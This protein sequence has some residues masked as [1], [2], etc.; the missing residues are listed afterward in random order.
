MAGD[1]D[2]D[3]DDSGGGAASGVG[4]GLVDLERELTCSICTDVLYQ[5]LT[6]LDCLH[7]FCGACV[8]EWFVWQATSA[9]TSTRH[10]T[11]SPYTC[12]SCRESVRGTKADWRLTALLEGFLRANP[13]KAKSDRDKQELGLHYKPGDD[14]I[15][16]VA[17]SHADEDSEDERLM[18]EIRELSMAHVDPE[19]AQ[20][21]TERASRDR[22]RRRRERGHAHRP[23]GSSSR[24]QQS[25]RWVAQQAVRQQQEEEEEG[26]REEEEA[27]RQI[28]H[29][30]SLRSLLSNSDANSSEDVQQEILQSIYSEG[31][32]NG[33][34]I[35]NLTPAQE[36][37]LTERIAEAYRRRRRHRDR[38]RNR[39]REDPS[40]QAQRQ[41]AT[42]PRTHIAHQQQS[43]TRT[44]PPVARPHIFEAQASTGAERQHRRS[45]SSTSQH[46]RLPAVS[47]GHYGPAA[48]SATDLSNPPRQEHPLSV[49]RPRA[50]S[51]NTRSSTDTTRMLR[52]DTQRVR[53]TSNTLSAGGLEQPLRP[54]HRDS[55]PAEPMRTRTASSL[56]E[57]AAPAPLA[58]QTAL[59]AHAA[60][61][62]D[63]RLLVSTSAF[64]PEVVSSEVGFLQSSAVTPY[65]IACSHCRRQA[66]G[67]TL[68]YNCSKCD[69]GM[70]NLCLQCYRDGKG[71]YHWYGFGLMAMYRWQ[72]AAEAEH[73]TRSFEYPHTLM[74]RKYIVAPSADADQTTVAV[75]TTN[76]DLQEGAFCESCLSFANTCYWYCNHCLE[77][78]WGYCNSC[79]LKGYHCTH[80]L[81]AIAH[82]STLHNSD[83]SRIP[84][85]I[86]VPHLK[87]DSYVLLPVL[88]DCDVCRNPI[89]EKETRFHCYR[90]SG[91]DYDICNECYHSLVAIGKISSVNGPNGWR[92]CL[93]GHRMSVVGY[94][95]TPTPAGP[96]KV[97]VT[98]KDMIG[99]WRLKDDA[100][101]ISA[102]DKRV[103]P[104]EPGT[105]KRSLAV[106]SRWP[107]EADKDELAFPKNAE[108][109][110]VEDL[111]ADWSVAVYAGKVGLVPS[112]YTRR[113]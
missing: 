24:Q 43:R 65:T 112:N 56:N 81:L 109:S 59:A 98:M 91:G 10:T 69:S 13:D 99:G 41:Q 29:Q 58:G 47:V 83:P 84:L 23:E 50:S 42:S 38:S 71:C 77:G 78:A 1:S 105:D 33:I 80:P 54:R 73:S 49:E 21:R 37:E 104:A 36:E 90:C 19:T 93:S 72:K 40:P 88:T 25:S 89:N 14:V 82:I 66:I 74:P 52:G 2:G 86:P 75:N 18:A 17:L 32:L 16:P 67:L 102:H 103:V 26:E 51:S 31:L 110:E 6:L 85:C 111:N 35:D 92:R 12:P 5:P 30:P 101:L 53:A 8:K 15:P 39:E 62:Q 60:P 55:R 108:F 3:V 97:R 4:G 28:E 11:A 113:L 95:D 20:R 68:H 7:T 45:A 96:G 46:T 76:L 79:V 106:W 100:G 34:D 48:R 64:A 107:K 61:Q 94:Q 44:R 22:Q 27:D 70:Y 63:V 87:Q 9:A 57:N